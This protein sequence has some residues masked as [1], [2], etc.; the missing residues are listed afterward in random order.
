MTQVVEKS[1]HI[2]IARPGAVPALA[3]RKLSSALV[4]LGG[5]L[6]ARARTLPVPAGVLAGTEKVLDVAAGGGALWKSFLLCVMLPSLCY[7]FY[8]AF[9]ASDDG[10]EAGVT[11]GASAGKGGGGGGG[12]GLDLSSVISKVTGGA[13]RST[14]QDAFIVL[15]YIKSRAIIADLG[16]REYLEK[17]YARQQCPLLFRLS[18]GADMEGLW[19]YWNGKVMVSIDTLSGIV[20]LQVQAYT[21]EDATNISQAVLDLSE[22]LVNNISNRGRSDAVDA[23]RPRCSLPQKS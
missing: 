21:P 9:I 19:K 4:R 12:G 18:K 13:G 11:V 1:R 3:G 17:I 22:K 14:V 10:A 2:E 15:N 5:Q 23:L 8:G 20:T 16:G 6:S 7:V